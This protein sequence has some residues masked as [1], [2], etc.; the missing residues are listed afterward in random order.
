MVQ[1]YAFD[2][3]DELRNSVNS[4]FYWPGPVKLTVYRRLFSV[5]LDLV[6]LGILLQ[7]AAVVRS[8]PAWMRT[9]VDGCIALPSVKQY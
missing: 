6:S 2:D 5:K 1:C 8:G 3:G 7:K 4:E 9:C